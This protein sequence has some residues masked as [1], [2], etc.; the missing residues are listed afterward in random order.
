MAPLWQLCSEG[1][2]ERVR[3]ALR[4][5][6][7]VNSRDSKETKTAL[8]WAVEK[9]HN[10]IVRLLLQQPTIQVNDKCRNEGRTALHNAALFNNV[11]AMQLLLANHQI[12]VNCQDNTGLTA[13][14][15]AAVR[16]NVEA[17]QLLL[18]N[19]QIESN[20]QN[21]E[22]GWTALHCAALKN[23]VEAMHLLLANQQVD[24]NYQDN[25]GWTA[26]HYAAD[27]KNVEAMQLLL[28]N[29]QVDVNLKDKEGNTALLYCD[30]VETMELLLANQKVDVNAASNAGDTGLHL[31]AQDN[32][33]ESIRMLLAHPQFNSANH[34]A[35]DGYTPA[36]VAAASQS[37]NALSELVNHQSVDLDLLDGDGRSLNQISAWFVANNIACYKFT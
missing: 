23:N 30:T 32:D 9:K 26:L 35:A 19:H 2:L 36:M 1:K 37:G 17:M 22:G 29:E 5:G 14:H 27:K 13:L 28:A 34:V 15:Y 12:E 3:A 21:N 7:D 24:V 8:M 6:E 10:G 20:C 33:V 25:E 18:A 31:A 11:D 4:G 16:N